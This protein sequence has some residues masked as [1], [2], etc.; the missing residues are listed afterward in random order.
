VASGVAVAGFAPAA[1]IS[2]RYDVTSVL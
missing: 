1:K 2:S